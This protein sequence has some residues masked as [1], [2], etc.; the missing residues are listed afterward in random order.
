MK[1]ALLSFILL[2]SFNSLT[3]SQKSN[4]ALVDDIGK[5]LA[6]DDYLKPSRVIHIVVDKLQNKHR[7]KTPNKVIEE[8]VT[9]LIVM[10]RKY[11]ASG[12][13]KVLVY[14]AFDHAIAGLLT[15]SSNPVRAEGAQCDKARLKLQE[16]MNIYNDALKAYQ[17][18]INGGSFSIDVGIP[19]IDNAL[20]NASR[21]STSSASS[22]NCGQL[23][24][25]VKDAAKEIG[26]WGATI[27][28]TCPYDK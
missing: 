18:C 5:V 23:L 20:G 24:D 19:M 11:R 12:E 26:R 9:E 2:L 25:L 8:A 10:R 7:L 14:R 17:R 22:G 3:F 15:G 6:D 1:T 4:L 16:W 21:G 27:Q 13:S 28:L